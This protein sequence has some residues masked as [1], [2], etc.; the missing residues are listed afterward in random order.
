M[1][2]PAVE[3]LGYLG[4]MSGGLGGF[5]KA[6]IIK[7]EGLDHFVLQDYAQFHPKDE[8]GKVDWD[9][10]AGR[11]RKIEYND[12]DALMDA[13]NNWGR[14]WESK[15][16]DWQDTDE[17]CGYDIPSSEFGEARK[18]WFESSR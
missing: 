10:I 13:F 5:R 1:A 4:G 18:R 11:H 17:R 15:N 14:P 8:S 6:L 9:S 7:S 16:W 2:E 3:Q 12:R